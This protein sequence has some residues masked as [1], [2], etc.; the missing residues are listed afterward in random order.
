M[1]LFLESPW[2]KLM[3][4]PV[5][6]RPLDSGLGGIFSIDWHGY[7]L[8]CLVNHI[9]SC[10]FQHTINSHAYQSSDVS[11][12]CCSFLLC[13]VFSTRFLLMSSTVFPCFVHSVSSH[14]VWQ[15]SVIL[16]A[17]LVL[18]QVPPNVS[19]KLTRLCRSISTS[20]CLF[21]SK[22]ALFLAFAISWYFARGF[23]Y[24]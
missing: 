22:R 11:S 10:D 8:L 13:A 2:R 9:E 4:M 18:S 20:P 17:A 14:N 1:T 15:Q 24:A 16:C 23:A 3:S 19:T 7:V 21:F 12:R 5:P 6:R